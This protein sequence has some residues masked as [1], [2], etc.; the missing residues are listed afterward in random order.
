MEVDNTSGASTDES[1][2]LSMLNDNPGYGD[3]TKLGGTG[4]ATILGT[5]CGVAVGVHGQGTLS[6]STGAGTLPVTIA[7]GGS[8]TCEFDGQFCGGLATLDNCA[9]GLEQTDTINATLTDDD[10]EG[11]AVTGSTS[12]TLKVDVCFSSSHP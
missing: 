6:G 9:S 1:E 11:H 4:A 8:Y 12:D 5:T 3:V 2:V 10:S 7:P